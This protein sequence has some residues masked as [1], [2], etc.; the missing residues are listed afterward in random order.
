MKE[1]LNINEIFLFDPVIPIQTTKSCF[2]SFLE[3]CNEIDVKWISENEEC[4]RKIPENTKVLFFVPHGTKSMYHNILLANWEPEKLENII[5]FGNPLSVFVDDQTNNT[6]IF[7]FLK[8]FTFVAYEPFSGGLKDKEEAK[9]LCE[10]GLNNTIAQYFKFNQSVKND[11][12]S[13]ITASSK[14]KK[15]SSENEFGIL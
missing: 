2:S 10:F 14:S 4:F 6:N 13:W 12:K 15:F 7:N 3:F 11:Y 9:S 5:I 1:I 8:P